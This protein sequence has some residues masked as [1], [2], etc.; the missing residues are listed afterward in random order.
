VADQDGFWFL[1]VNDVHY[2]DEAGLPWLEGAFR[3]LRSHPERPEFCLLL[4]D[5]VESASERSLTTVRHLV[6]HLGMPVHV[7]A[8]NH[9]WSSDTDRRLF[10]TFF[11]EA[12]NHWFEH[13]GW[14]FVVLDS[15][16]GNVYEKVA[17]PDASLAWLDRTRPQLKADRPTVLCTHFPQGPDVR[18]RSTNAEDLLARCK[19]L[20]LRAVF[21]G[22]YH[23]LTERRLGD[24]VLT[25]NRCCSTTRKNH[26]GSPEKGYFLCHASPTGELTR[27]FVAV[28]AG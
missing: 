10:D 12:K 8:G 11:P 16:A 9:D 22:H 26:D 23:G 4:G 20:N 14:Q 28:P 6:D 5:L 2:V 18:Y 17:I 27:R 25:T 3:Q 7:T 13:R 1:V 21:S 24:V 19:G 15:S